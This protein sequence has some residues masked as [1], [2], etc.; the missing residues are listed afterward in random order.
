MKKERTN[1]QIKTSVIVTNLNISVAVPVPKK[2]SLPKN[3]R[4]FEMLEFFIMQRDKPHR[5]NCDYPYYDS[6]QRLLSWAIACNARLTSYQMAT[7]SGRKHVEFNFEFADVINCCNFIMELGYY[8]AVAEL[9]W[10]RFDLICAKFFPKKEH[11]ITFVMRC[12]FLH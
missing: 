11:Q 4:I 5:R 3:K 7:G 10:M 12:S 8:E 2:V 9:F 1:H 6:C